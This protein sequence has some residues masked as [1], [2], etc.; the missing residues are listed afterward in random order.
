MVGVT[1]PL[2]F[3][4]SCV[5]EATDPV[6]G[7]HRDETSLVQKNIMAAQADSLLEM[8]LGRPRAHSHA[9]SHAHAHHASAH[10]HAK[11]PHHVSDS[12]TPTQTL[13]AETFAQ[14]RRHRWE[15][16]KRYRQVHYPYWVM[17]EN[18]YGEFG[19]GTTTSSLEIP[20]PVD[21]LE[22]I[23]AV[24][25]G[26][27]F[28]VFAV[29]NGTAYGAGYNHYG[30][31]GDGTKVDSDTPV[32]VLGVDNVIGVAAGEDHAVFLKIDGT[33][34]A[35]GRNTEGQLGDGTVTDREQV[36]QVTNVANVKAID[37]GDYCTY[38]LTYDGTVMAT[39]YNIGGKLGVGTHVSPVKVPREV[40]QVPSVKDLSVSGTHALFLTTS[41]LVYAVGRNL[42]GQLGVGTQND[43]ST[44]TLVSSLS[45]VVQ[46]A[47]EKD[48]SVFLLGNGTVYSAGFNSFGSFADGTTEEN[49]SPAR[50][51]IENVKDIAASDEYTVFVTMDGRAHVAGKY[52]DV[53]NTHAVEIPA[54]QRVVSVTSGTHHTFFLTEPSTEAPEPAPAPAASPEAPEPAPAPAASP[55]APEPAPAPAASPE[56]PEPAPAPAASPEAPEP[57]PAPAASPEAPATAPAPAAS[58]EEVSSPAATQSHNMRKVEDLIFPASLMGAC[59]LFMVG[60]GLCM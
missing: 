33:V 34:Y 8:G 9:H 48:R 43:I 12:D 42:Q 54:V 6:I 31:L 16:Y 2:F 20:K 60:I 26:E 56:A 11:K 24:D 32:K 39:G 41:G 18:S 19:D 58:P 49:H 53:A 3:I 27:F 10:K 4:L 13:D 14:K 15:D 44:P 5:L 23:V 17:G 46:I 57:A 35:V 36:V 47:A 38:F 7:N 28:T 52:G 59:L 51:T 30:E 55:E 37:A 50:A 21:S 22:D 1:A 40:V 45:N 29:G 25:A